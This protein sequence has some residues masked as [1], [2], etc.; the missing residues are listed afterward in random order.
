MEWSVIDVDSRQSIKPLLR[1]VKKIAIAIN[2]RKTRAWR[3]SVLAWG[4]SVNSLFCIVALGEDGLIEHKKRYVFLFFV[5]G[6]YYLCGDKL[7]VLRF[8]ALQ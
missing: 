5:L 2:N 4:I 7:N 8:P 6:L 1:H 3:F